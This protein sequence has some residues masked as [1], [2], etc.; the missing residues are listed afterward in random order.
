MKLNAISEFKYHKKCIRA[1]KALKWNNSTI[2]GTRSRVIIESFCWASV[3]SVA[4]NP[5]INQDDVPRLLPQM[6]ISA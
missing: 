5:A 3:A 4:R 6:I 1:G 2:H